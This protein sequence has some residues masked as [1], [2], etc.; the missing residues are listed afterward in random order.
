MTAAVELPALDG[1][2]TLGFLA[3]LGVLRLLTDEAKIETRLSFSESNANAILHSPLTS[4][5][6]VVDILVHVV[7]HIPS[8]GAIPGVPAGFPQQPGTGKDPMR[9]PRDQLRRTFAQLADGQRG[10][11]ACRW[12]AAL[13]TDLAA[14]REGRAALTPYSAPGGK[15]SVRSFFVKP[16]ELLRSKEPATLVREALVRWRRVDNYTGENL[17]HRVL[18]SAADHPSGESVPAGVP[19]ATWLAIMAL[20]ML[21]LTGNGTNP[22][23]TL[24]HNVVGSRQPIMVWPLWRQPL[25]SYAVVALLE[26]PALRPRQGTDAPVVPRAGLAPLGVFFVGA[27]ARQPVKGAKSAGVLAPTRI[28]LVD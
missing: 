4:I 17:D 2:D 1:R 5:D 19:G 11:E 9:V 13:L 7:D 14:D 24:W 12:L 16:L 3:A 10:P 25:D 8:A 27:A 6:E 22:Q 23:A 18:R 28:S 26:H 21:R 20:P 15:Q